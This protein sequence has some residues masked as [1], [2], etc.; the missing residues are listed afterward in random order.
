MRTRVMLAALVLGLPAAGRG[1]KPDRAASGP[2][3]VIELGPRKDSPQEAPP[4]G[5]GEP[6]D[7]QPTGQAATRPQGTESTQVASSGTAGAAPAAERTLEQQWAEDRAAAVKDAG[8]R[9][10]L[11]G[12]VASLRAEVE[13]LRASQAEEKA[14]ADALQQQLSEERAQQQAEAARSTSERADATGQAL[15]QMDGALQ[16]LS[17][18]DASGLDAALAQQA[19]ALAGAQQEAAARGAEREAQQSG[20]AAEAIA[21]AREALARGDLY[22]ARLALGR[23]AR[24]AGDANGL[25]REGAAGEAGQSTAGTGSGY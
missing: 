20:V 15:G 13:S 22:A 24:S 19:Q 12:E 4:Q 23:A 11:A 3:H 6:A 5:S 9:T 8:E 7:A 16:S 25:A 21:A 2:V 17:S 14:R 10:R 1:E 18:G